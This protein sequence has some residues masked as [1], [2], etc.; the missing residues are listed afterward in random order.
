MLDPVPKCGLDNSR[1]AVDPVV[2][3]V[4]D[5]AHA[6]AIVLQ[7]DKVAVLRSERAMN[8]I[9]Q[10][11]RTLAIAAVALVAVGATAAVGRPRVISEPLPGTE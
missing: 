10:K 5:Q 6:I 2:A 4:G 8:F 3:A 7:A 9:W 1:I 11:S